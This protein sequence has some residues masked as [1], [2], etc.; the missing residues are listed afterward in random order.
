MRIIKFKHKHTERT[1]RGG[2]NQRER[3]RR[4]VRE[5]DRG[6]DREHLIPSTLTVFYKWGGEA[7]GER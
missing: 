4:G 3:E 2:N 1:H 7:I 6:S 5:E